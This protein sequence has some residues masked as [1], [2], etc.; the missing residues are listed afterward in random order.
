[1]FESELFRRSHG[2]RRADWAI[3]QRV[4]AE[5]LEQEWFFNL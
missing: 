3:N 2:I 5:T 1:M 4:F